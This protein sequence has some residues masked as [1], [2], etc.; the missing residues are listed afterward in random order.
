[1]KVTAV[2]EATFLALAFS[3]RVVETW[4]MVTAA[5]AVS[6]GAGLPS[7]VSVPVAVASSVTGA[8]TVLVQVKVH[9]APGFRTVFTPSELF[10]N[11]AA[12]QKDPV[13]VTA[14]RASEPV[15]VSV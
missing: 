9:V 1:M 14:L 8:V 13:T 7:T 12:P 15:F 3:V 5:C 2:P 6:G 10:V 11:V 4:V